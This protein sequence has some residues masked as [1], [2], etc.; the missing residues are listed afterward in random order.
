MPA[1]ELAAS[2]MICRAKMDFYH[3]ASSLTEVNS[4]IM[5]YTSASDWLTTLNHILQ[6]P[7]T[8][9]ARESWKCINLYNAGR[10]FI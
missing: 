9:A 2:I 10:G 4:E 5:A 6:L 7:D 3:Y 8:L 1:L